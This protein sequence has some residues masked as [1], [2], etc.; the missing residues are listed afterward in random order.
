MSGRGVRGDM[1]KCDTW[2]LDRQFGSLLARM[3]RYFPKWWVD[4]IEIK[5]EIRR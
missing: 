3:S 4:A 5:K 1:D 2:I